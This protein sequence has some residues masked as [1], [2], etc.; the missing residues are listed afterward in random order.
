MDGHLDRWLGRLAVGFYVLAAVLVVIFM[1]W[2]S[3]IFGPSF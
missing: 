1:L 2:P 3:L